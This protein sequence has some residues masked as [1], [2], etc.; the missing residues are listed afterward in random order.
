MKR[1]ITLLIAAAAPLAIAFI[2][3]GCGGSASGAPYS[4]GPY[5]SAAPV[6]APSAAASTAKVA[7][8]NS[9][10]G[11][12]AVDSRGR[13]LYLFEKHKNRH[14][15]CSGQCAKYWPPLLTNGKP[16]ARAGVKQLL[17]GMTRRANGSQQVTYAGHPLYRF[18]EDKKPGQTKGQGSQAFGAGWDVLSPAG[19]KIE[20]DG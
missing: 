14:S 11:R 1:K 7:V 6:K 10:L 16:V 20:S 9:P 8:A 2:A 13:T 15:A 12:I 4:S 18:V 5:G 19:K 17:L 3:S